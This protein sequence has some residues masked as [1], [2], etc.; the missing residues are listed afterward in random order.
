MSIGRNVLKLSFGRLATQVVSLIAAPIMA[1]L[2]LPKHFGTLQ[3]FGSIASVIIAITCLGYE[4]SI[5]LGENKK[6][7]SASFVLS[8]LLTIIVTLLVLTA[9]PILK[10]DI[11]RWF[12][13]PEL[14]IFLWLLPLAVFI[15][16]MRKPLRYWAAY[17]GRFGAM[18]WS[19]FCCA[20]SGK[21]VVIAWALIIGASVT[22]LFAGYFVSEAF[23]IL[24]LLVFL[25]RRL[26]SDIKNANLDFKM[27]W[28]TAKDYKKFPI[29][30]TWSGLLSTISRNL[31]AIILG[32]CFSTTVVGYYA[33]GKRLI[34]LPMNLLSSSIAKVFFPTAAKEYNETGT[35]SKIVSNVFRKLVQIGVF[36]MI[37]LGVLGAPL[38]GLVFGEKWIEAGVYTQILSIWMLLVFITSPLCAAFDILQRQGTALAFNIG[39]V[40]SRALALLLGAQ[41]GGPRMALGVF[42]VVSIIGWSFM[43]C[44][45]LRNSGVSLRWGLG[46]FLKYAGSSSLLLLPTGYFAW[47][48]GNIFIALTSLGFGALLYAYGLYRFD[49]GIREFT[50]Q[51]L[52]KRLGLGQWNKKEKSLYI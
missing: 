40:S 37:A 49:P 51:I 25:S 52:S 31:P 23:G 47:V 27:I 1:W 2:F 29:F 14:K 6:K 11:A 26:V 12:K 17:E 39:L 13:A 18:A 7:T 34:S 44:W 38:F 21:L 50:A 8:V 48:W 32:L 22:G 16:G 45:I 20:L 28:T 9:V 3:I 30:T 24:L 46:T 41:M 33:I 42:V 4:L 19:E 36:P 10:E 35:L 5:P 43:L 15:G